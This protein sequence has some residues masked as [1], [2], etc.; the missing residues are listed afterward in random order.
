[1]GYL[2]YIQKHDTFEKERK[3]KQKLEKALRKEEVKSIRAVQKQMARQNQKHK[4]HARFE[5]S[6]QKRKRSKQQLRALAYS[7]T[8][9]KAASAAY[10]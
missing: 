4:K 9:Y 2:V 10:I 5:T 1:M 3:E 8:D 7:F 6:G